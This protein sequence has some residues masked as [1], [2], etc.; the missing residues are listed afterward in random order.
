MYLFSLMVTE[1]YSLSRL[2]ACKGVQQE[3]G[4]L[5]KAQEEGKGAVDSHPLNIFD[6][7]HD[8]P[9]KESNGDQVHVCVGS[10]RRGWV[11]R[12]STCGLVD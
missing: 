12:R 7:F 6:S 5:D 2:V 3:R 11:E 8:K 4:A 9:T 1:F 10:F